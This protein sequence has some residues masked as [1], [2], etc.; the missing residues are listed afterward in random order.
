MTDPLHQ[1]RRRFLGRAGAGV[2]AA[3]LG[4]LLANDALGGASAQHF[5]AKVK[6]VIYLMQTGAPSHVDLFDY[7]PHL[8]D[9]RG[10]DIPESVRAGVRLSTMTAS[11]KKYPVLPPLKPFRREEKT[12]MWLS[13][14]KI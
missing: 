13:D 12:G 2:G 14:L 8:L 1:T 5:P 10:E 6:R 4:Q 3:A 7:K 11:Y 9:K